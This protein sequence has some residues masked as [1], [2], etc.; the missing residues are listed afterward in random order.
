MTQEQ[1]RAQTQQA[2]RDLN[3]TLH[4]SDVRR[5]KRT[6]WIV[7]F[8]ENVLPIVVEPYPQTETECLK[9]LKIKISAPEYAGLRHPQI[10]TL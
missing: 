4:I 6:S 2:I 5:G 9:E 10:K 1:V 8:E 3:S 7:S